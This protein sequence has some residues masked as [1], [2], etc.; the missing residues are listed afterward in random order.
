M[1]DDGQKMMIYRFSGYWRDVGTIES[2]WEANMDMLSGSDIDLSSPSWRIYAR[3]PTSPPHYMGDNATVS[4]SLVTEGCDI[5]GGVFNSVL[6]NDVTVEQGAFVEYSIVMP[7]A[8]IERGAVV[9][10]AIIAENAVI[11]PGARIGLPPDAFPDNPEDWGV[12]V[13][14]SGIT[15]GEGK[16]VGAREMAAADML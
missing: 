5:Y 4:H 2:L 6:F 9:K 8:V 16:A 1:L 3:N 7:G 11:K 13:V 10:Y 14:A 12:A 15:I